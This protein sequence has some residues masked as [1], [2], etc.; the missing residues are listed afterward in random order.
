[1]VLS[2]FILTKEQYYREL[3]TLPKA[4]CIANLIIPLPQVTLF[5]ALYVLA[6]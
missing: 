4:Q 2:I 5:V 6:I 1:M 3:A